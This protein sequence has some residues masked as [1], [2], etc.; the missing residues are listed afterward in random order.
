MMSN[1]LKLKFLTVICFIL[2]FF[3]FREEVINLVV[4]S[5]FSPSLSEA[6]K[7]VSNKT[8]L[9]SSTVIDIPVIIDNKEIINETNRYRKTEDLRELQTN[10]LLTEAAQHKLDDIFKNGY[11]DHIS[12]SGK[13]PAELAEAVGY[14]YIVVG[15]NLALGD[16]TSEADVVR[17][18]MESSG[19]RENIMNKTYQEIGVAAARRSYNGENTL[20]IV[21]EF[22]VPMSACGT[23]NE[24]RT[25][26]ITAYKKQLDDLDKELKEY[27]NRLRTIPRSSA[28]HQAEMLAYNALV[29]DYNDLSR[30]TSNLITTYNVEASQYNDCLER[31]RY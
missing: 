23:F 9:H 27:Q 1:S 6:L 7:K 30:R 4:K 12:P 18:W 29:K 22:G 16:F 10:D 19:H 8:L 28:E 15:E 2:V 14:K 17:S 31:Y 11:F 20:I 21:Q 3:A 24:S 25:I 26:L 5:N 13:G